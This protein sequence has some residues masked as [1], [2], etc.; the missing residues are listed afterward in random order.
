LKEKLL[1]FVSKLIS[2][3]NEELIDLFLDFQEILQ[4][5]EENIS[6]VKSAQSLEK[7]K[8]LQER[9]KIFLY[10]LSNLKVFKFK[11]FSMF[12]SRKP[13]DIWK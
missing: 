13:T 4:K 5:N 1:F 7:M 2:M 6:E 11:F 3:T 8:D 9:V 10:H 12:F